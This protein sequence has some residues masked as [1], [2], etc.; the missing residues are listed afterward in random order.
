[1]FAQGSSSKISIM[2]LVESM[3]PLAWEGDRGGSKFSMMLLVEFVSPMALE[4]DGEDHHQG[5][6]YH[7]GDQRQR[8]SLQL[9]G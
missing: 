3:C 5:G 9:V 2:L 7:S 1:M 4:G 8:C 6:C